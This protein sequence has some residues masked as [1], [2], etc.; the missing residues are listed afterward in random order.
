MSYFQVFYAGAELKLDGSN[1]I[2][3]IVSEEQ[4]YDQ[5]QGQPTTV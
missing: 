2:P 3:D 5:S 1:R 4:I